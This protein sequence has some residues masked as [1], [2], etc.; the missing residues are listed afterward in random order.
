[1]GANTAQ[2]GDLQNYQ[3]Q[4]NNDRDRYQQMQEFLSQM[5]MQGAGGM[6]QAAIGQGYANA[7]GDMANSSMWNNIL[8]GGAGMFGGAGGMG[9]QGGQGGG[10]SNAAQNGMS[11]A[12]FAALAG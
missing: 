9:G 8:S 12:E 3:N 1:M 2:M 11:Y 5:G 7:G 10:M 6:S 4:Q